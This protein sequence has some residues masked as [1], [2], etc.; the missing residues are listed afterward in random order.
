MQKIF[1]NL[2]NFFNYVKGFIDHIQDLFS[3]LIDIVQSA[4]A[5][6]KVFISAFPNWLT[7]LLLVL[8]AVCVLYKF[9]GREGSS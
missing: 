3:S 7:S 1:D 4:V 8:I 5:Y 2:T 6:L 9:L